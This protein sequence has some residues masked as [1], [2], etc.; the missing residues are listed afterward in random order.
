VTD[1][2]LFLIVEFFNVR[3]LQL[4]YSRYRNAAAVTSVRINWIPVRAQ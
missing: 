3:A 4:L 1:G 2:G